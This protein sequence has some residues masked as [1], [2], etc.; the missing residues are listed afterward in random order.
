MQNL[1]GMN[2]PADLPFLLNSFS[3]LCIAAFSPLLHMACCKIDGMLS[4]LISR[5]G[6]SV[7]ALT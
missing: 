5:D 4:G 3:F 1:R 7:R 2:V 6:S